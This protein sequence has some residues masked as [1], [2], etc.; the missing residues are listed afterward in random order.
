MTCDG[1]NGSH[2]HRSRAWYKM[3]VYQNRVKVELYKYTKESGW[4]NEPDPTAAKT[5]Y[6][7]KA[8]E[9]DLLG[10]VNLDGLVSVDDVTYL[11]M[12]IAHFTDNEGNALIDETDERVFAV[13]DLDGDGILT[14]NDATAVQ[15]ILAGYE[16]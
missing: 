13:S 15:M 6:K 7:F 16:L 12:H 5:V 3:Y 4:T 14:I 10:D 11:Q 1:S 8:A 9:K 2:G